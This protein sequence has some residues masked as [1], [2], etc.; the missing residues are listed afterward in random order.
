MH[1]ET[2]RNYRNFMLF[3]KFLI[4]FLGQVYES[5]ME[6]FGRNFFGK[7]LAGC[8][9]SKKNENISSMID[10]GSCIIFY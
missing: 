5:K 2:R 8:Y 1:D 10:F 9:E 7:L 3:R 6:L 4:S